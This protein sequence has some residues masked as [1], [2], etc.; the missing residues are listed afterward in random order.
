M[1]H[2]AQ[3]ASPL[4]IR[5]DALLDQP[6][7]F[8]P[9]YIAFE[10]MEIEDAKIQVADMTAACQRKLLVAVMA[11]ENSTL[12]KSLDP[13]VLAAADATARVTRSL[14]DLVQAYKDARSSLQPLNTLHRAREECN[15]RLHIAQRLDRLRQLKV[16]LDEADTQLNLQEISR[17]RKQIGE[18]WSRFPSGA[19]DRLPL[20]AE[21]RAHFNAHCRKRIVVLN[22]SVT[23]ED[24][25]SHEAE[26][27]ELFRFDDGTTLTSI[28]NPALL[29]AIAKTLRTG[30]LNLSNSPLKPFLALSELFWQDPTCVFD[31]DPL[32]A[33]SLSGEE[34]ADVIWRLGH[35]VTDQNAGP[36][37]IC[38]GAKLLAGTLTRFCHCLKQA[39]WLEKIRPQSDIIKIERE[40]P[41]VESGRFWGVFRTFVIAWDLLDQLLPLSAEF[42]RVL[43]VQKHIIDASNQ[44]DLLQYYERI[45]QL[46][47]RYIP[48]QIV[49]PKEADATSLV[50]MQAGFAPLLAGKSGPV[51]DLLIDIWKE[52]AI[53][54]FGNAQGEAIKEAG[55]N[56][57]ATYRD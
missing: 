21:L 27:S 52:C 20:L 10:M 15:R 19:I 7:L 44:R 45:R 53:E 43:L 25:F 3:A 41:A 33:A 28:D 8:D 17:I 50:R 51:K 36:E 24:A 11:D 39:R 30:A 57:R 46:A 42:L 49:F 22:R 29:F 18:E 16:Q 54:F 5:L 55:D 47:W 31:K 9:D 12:V 2:A 6:K 38:L 1:T 23:R 4:V 34:W 32:A 56:L 35:M 13:S 14:Q 40:L 48:Y 26:L 37:F